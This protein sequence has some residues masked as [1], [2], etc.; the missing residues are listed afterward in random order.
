MDQHYCQRI[1]DPNPLVMRLTFEDDPAA[2]GKPA[3]FVY[4]DAD[5]FVDDH[6]YHDE[7]RKWWLCADCYDFHQIFDK[8]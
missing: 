3:R 5:L 7:P 1:P 4:E 8:I 2:C 6:P